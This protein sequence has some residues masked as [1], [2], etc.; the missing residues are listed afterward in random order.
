LASVW[1]ARVQHLFAGA[2]FKIE[3]GDRLKSCVAAILEQ[4]K[5]LSL[6]PLVSVK[7]G[8]TGSAGAPPSEIVVA[9]RVAEA[10]LCAWCA[11]VEIY[12]DT[13]QEI[14]RGYF[15]RPGLVDR[16]FNLSL[17]GEIFRDLQREL[18]RLEPERILH[19][20]EFEGDRGVV[21]RAREGDAVLW[22]PNIGDAARPARAPRIEMV[23][24]RQ[25]AG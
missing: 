13:F 7:L 6:H 3:P 18:S 15:L 25:R 14:D 22:L 24:S 23:G 17:A 2:L 5:R 16:R 20:V 11:P 19:E 10:I 12:L 1:D 4:A 8:P 9:N 21:F